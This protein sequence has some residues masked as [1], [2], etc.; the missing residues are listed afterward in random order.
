V[1]FRFAEEVRGN[2][3]TKI[4]S[5]WRLFNTIGAS[6]GR[7]AR[8]DFVSGDAVM[9]ATLPSDQL[10][11]AIKDVLVYEDYELLDAFKVSRL[12]PGATVLDAGAFVGLYSLKAS[13]YADRVVA[14][15][16]GER[17]FRYLESNIRLNKAKNVEARQVALSSRQGVSAFS[18]AG[19]ISALS[20]DGKQVV[21]TTTLDDLVG[22]LGHVDL[23]KMDIEGAEYE[24]FAACIYALREI[25]KI[26]AEV[27]L[28]DSDQV[29][30]LRGLVNGLEGAGFKVVTMPSPCQSMT[31]G[32]TKPWNCPLKRYNDGNASLY[33]LLLSLIYGAGP[34][35]RAAKRS[36]ETGS[37]GLLYAY[38]R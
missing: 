2:L 38:R 25:D 21:R 29:A 13:R 9:R 23:L 30:A 17:N 5:P 14:L 12:P 27:H 32:A 18:Q 10:W 15:E 37:E 36:M 33:R 7:D 35:A 26:A 11:V 28:R 20:E 24:V 4:L 3:A 19:T 16:P 8:V 34:I 1:R 6:E 22:T 31:Y